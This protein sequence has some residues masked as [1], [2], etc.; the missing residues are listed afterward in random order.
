MTFDRKREIS[1][2]RHFSFTSKDTLSDKSPLCFRL[3][4]DINYPVLLRLFFSGLFNSLIYSVDKSENSF[5]WDLN[6]SKLDN[7][8]FLLLIM[9]LNA[10][11]LGVCMFAFLQL[12]Q[13]S[14]AVIEGATDEC[15]PSSPLPLLYQMYWFSEG[16]GAEKHCRW[17]SRLTLNWPPTAHLVVQGG[18]EGN[19]NAWSPFCRILGLTSSSLKRISMK[20]LTKPMHNL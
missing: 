17:L 16:D 11:C 14:P 6:S 19:R 10:V 20:K 8:P 13:V 2:K 18:K 15:I 5:R 9:F 12:N 7:C 4:E 3:C 1:L